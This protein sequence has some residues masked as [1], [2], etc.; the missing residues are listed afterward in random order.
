MMGNLIRIMLDAFTESKEKGSYLLLYL[1]AL[2]LG[3]AVA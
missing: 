3:L 1:L 2:G